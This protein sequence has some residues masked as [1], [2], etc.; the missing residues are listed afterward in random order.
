MAA[1]ILHSFRRLFNVRSISYR[2]I[3]RA[4]FLRQSFDDLL[5]K[6]NVPSASKRVFRCLVFSAVAFTTKAKIDPPQNPTDLNLKNNTGGMNFEPNDPRLRS[7]ECLKN[8]AGLSVDS[9]S[10]VLSQTVYAVTK[11]EKEYVELMNVLIVLMEYQLQVLGH[12]AEEERIGDL[13]VET[14]HEVNKVRQRKEDLHLLFGSV[15]KLADA[16]AEVAFAAGAEYAST[17]TGERL[18]S[19]QQ[20]VRRVQAES[21]EAERRLHEAQARSIEVQSQHEEKMQTA[22]RQQQ[23]DIQYAD[24]HQ[25]TEA[26]TDEKQPFSE[27]EKTG[28]QDSTDG[29]NGDKGVV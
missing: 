6:C 1:P 11:I 2:K 25:K 5:Q 10:A 18:H 21:E 14:R 4:A 27:D 29:F 26:A 9:T 17:S 3:Y 13:I 23:Q 20:E 19:A 16:T 8:A 15:E 24:D 22:L 12:A 28:D 7:H